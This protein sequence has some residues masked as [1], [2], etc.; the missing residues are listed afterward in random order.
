MGLRKNGLGN[1]GGCLTSDGQITN[2]ADFVR[3]IS[4]RADIGEINIRREVRQE[5][6]ADRS[7]EP[8]AA[9]YSFE[10]YSSTWKVYRS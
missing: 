8:V 4:A 10:V 1:N 2:V 6:L 5:T 9:M 3:N 7:L